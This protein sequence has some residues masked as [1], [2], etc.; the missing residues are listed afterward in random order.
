[1]CDYHWCNASSTAL[2]TLRVGGHAFNGSSSGLGSFDS[3]YGV[4]LA[5]FAVGFRSL[6]RMN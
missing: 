3:G 2:R 4:G 5:G 1:M 6:T